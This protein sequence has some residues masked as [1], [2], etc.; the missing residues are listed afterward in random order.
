M[1]KGGGAPSKTEST[2]HQSSLPEYAAPY[3]QRLMSRAEAETNQPYVA[4]QGPRIA[5][6]TA[7]EK[8]AFQM[9]TQYSQKGTGDLDAARSQAMNASNAA[10]GLTGYNATTQGVQ[11]NYDP[12]VF[13]T[14]R[15]TPEDIL[16]FMN[17]YIQG[18]LD[19]QRREAMRQGD[20]RDQRIQ[21]EAA[22]A[23]AFGGYRH[24]LMES[25]NRRNT[26][27]ILMDIESKGLFDAYQTAAGISSDAFKDWQARSLQAQQ[28]GEQARQ[29]GATYG[30]E[31]ERFNAQQALEAQLQSAQVR[32]QAAATQGQAAQAAADI[33]RLQD[34]IARNQI[35]TLEAVG[36]T[37]REL[38]QSALDKAYEDFINQRDYE[39]NNLAF[40]SGLLHGVPVTPQSEIVQYQAPP[41]T[42]SQIGGLGLTGLGLY[43]ALSGGAA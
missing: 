16:P 18:V 27:R 40:M 10:Q 19:I 15:F 41:S 13:S 30:Q 38:G 4:Y 33:S 23:G 26:D 17:P 35:G 36:A 1:G 5:G 3:Y 32:L 31:A 8:Q 7:P 34:E 20:I 25:E 39:R 9:A 22:K 42:A 21:G 6:F 12:S 24:G 43:R 14:Q 11:G 2:V 37:Q 28:M 29:F